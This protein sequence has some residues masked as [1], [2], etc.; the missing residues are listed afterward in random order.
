MKKASGI[1][2]RPSLLDDS[3][4]SDSEEDDVQVPV[5]KKRRKSKHTMTALQKAG[6]SGVGLI[7]DPPEL[8]G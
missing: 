6:A 3:S 2:R 7:T 1:M 4:S 5:S 8:E